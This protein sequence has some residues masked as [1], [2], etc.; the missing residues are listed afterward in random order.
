MWPNLILSWK[1]DSRGCSSTRQACFK[2]VLVTLS[3]P[4]AL[5]VF[6][7]CTALLRLR[8]EQISEAVS[9]ASIG[10]VE[11]LST[12]GEAGCCDDD[13]LVGRLEPASDV[14]ALRVSNGVV[15]GESPGIWID[16]GV[17]F[18]EKIFRRRLGLLELVEQ[19]CCQFS[20]LL[21]LSRLL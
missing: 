2:E 18:L 7:E 21:F 1:M 5:F 3:G 14:K 10:L 6:R 15:V 19:K 11:S 16:P 9:E 4:G 20:F 8:G 12:S 13:P 17:R